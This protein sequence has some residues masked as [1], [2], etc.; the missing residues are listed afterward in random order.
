MV[1]QTLKME[2]WYFSETL[3]QN[4]LTWLNSD[5]Y[6][7]TKKTVLS[8]LCSLF[9]ECTEIWKILVRTYIHKRDIYGLLQAI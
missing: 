2:T 6:L 9:D 4:P 1:M 8:S 7:R 3:L 5:I